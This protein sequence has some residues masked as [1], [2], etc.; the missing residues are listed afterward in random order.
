MTVMVCFVSYELQ[1]NPS[2]PSKGTIA[3][4]Y[5]SHDF[6]R[7]T[8]IVDPSTTSVIAWIKYPP[9]VTIDKARTQDWTA[10]ALRDAGASDLQVSRVFHAFSAEYCGC[11]IG[12]IAMEFIEIIDCDSNDAELAAKAVQTLIGLQAPQTATFGHVGGGAFF[13]EWLPNA[14]YKSN[15]DFY[16][17]IHKI[18]KFLRIDFH[19]DIS[20]HG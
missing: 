5:V 20:R 17:H 16:A 15:Q 12:Y 8:A 9:N 7:G 3:A 19:G 1:Y 18:S 10:K 6:V 11:S 4:H 2:P 13:P 14:N